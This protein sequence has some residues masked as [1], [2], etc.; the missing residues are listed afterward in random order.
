MNESIESWPLHWPL[1]F[2]RTLPGNRIK[3]P[4]KQGMD[5]SQRYLRKQLD[6]M[7][8]GRL[9]VSTN[10]PV[11][12]DGGLYT[13]WMSRK[14]EDPGV[15]IYFHLDGK[16]ISMCCDQYLAVW[17]NIYAL[18]KSIEALRAI[19]R[20][21][22]SEFIQRAFTGFKELPEA[23]AS[24]PWWEVLGVDKNAMPSVIRR[25]YLEKVKTAHPDA[26]GSHD[27]FIRIQEAFNQSTQ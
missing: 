16:D 6:L 18:G 24:E 8:A 13:D 21:G 17:E 9:I 7:G 19:D 15:A 4:F 22:V 5:S 14:I 20:Y 11:R 10:I 3:S 12:K 26:G 27:Q 25:A 1:G 23:G 2:K